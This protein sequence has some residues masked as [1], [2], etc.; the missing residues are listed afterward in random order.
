MIRIATAAWSGLM[1][2]GVIVIRSRKRHIETLVNM[3]VAKV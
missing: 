3:R 1:N 2:A